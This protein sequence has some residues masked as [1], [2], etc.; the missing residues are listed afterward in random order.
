[1][2]KLMIISIVM[3]LILITLLTRDLIKTYKIRR[4]VKRT[5]NNCLNI[6]K[7]KE[8]EINESRIYC[9]NNN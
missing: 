6:A 1:M 9:T 5:I 4:M 8:R 3:S 7:K 2:E